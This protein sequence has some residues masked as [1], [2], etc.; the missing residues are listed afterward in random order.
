MIYIK[1]LGLDKYIHYELQFEKALLDVIGWQ[2]E[3]K[4]SIS[5]FFS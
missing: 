1:Q 3:K 5:A 2:T 4:A